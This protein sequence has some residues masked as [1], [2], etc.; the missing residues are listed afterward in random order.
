M[1]SRPHAVAILG[2]LP[3][4]PGAACKGAADADDVFF[5]LDNNRTQF[6]I[7]RARTLC[8]RCPERVPCLTWAMNEN[9]GGIW[10]GVGERG[11]RA[12]KRKASA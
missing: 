1:S 12:M 8:D 11:R 7:A 10:G 2:P 5:P 3:D 6:A 9:V 4:L